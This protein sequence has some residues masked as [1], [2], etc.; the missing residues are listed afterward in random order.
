[1]LILFLLGSLGVGNFA[2]IYHGQNNK[3]N[4]LQYAALANSLEMDRQMKC[5]KNKE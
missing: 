1:V 4:K 2:L 3:T 5:L